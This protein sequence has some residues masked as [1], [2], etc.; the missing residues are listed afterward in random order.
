M[1]AASKN[2]LTAFA[3]IDIL[4]GVSTFDRGILFPKSTK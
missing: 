3:R 2:P 4:I 1:Y